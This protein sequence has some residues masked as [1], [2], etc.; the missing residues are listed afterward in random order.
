MVTYETS[1]VF[2]IRM[3]DFGFTLYAYGF[4]TIILKIILNRVKF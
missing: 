2:P 1:L 4:V 3:P